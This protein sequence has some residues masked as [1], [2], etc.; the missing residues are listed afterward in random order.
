MTQVTET[1]V[2][3]SN[4]TPSTGCNPYLN[5]THSD[6]R[7]HNARNE[8]SNDFLGV[9]QDPTDKHLHRRCSDAGTEYQW[10]ATH[11]SGRNDRADKRKAGT[12][13]A[14]QSRSQ[15]SELTTLDERGDAGSKQSHRHQ[16]TGVFS[17]EFQ[18]SGN[19]KGWG[20]NGYKDGQ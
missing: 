2:C 3:L 16:I 17:I 4:G 5:Q 13:D 1:T 10:K 20:D 15:S 9:F 8:R 19:N 6:E 7:N 11:G 14:E 18:R 12:L